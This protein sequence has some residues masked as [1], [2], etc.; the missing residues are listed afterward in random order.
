MMKLVDD[1]RNWSKWWSIRLSLIGGF[2]LAL[3]EAYP[4]A[5]GHVFSALPAEISGAISQDILKGVGI[6]CILASP[7]A[8]VIRQQRLGDKN[9]GKQ[10]DD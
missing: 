2:L 9:E 5:V 4:H 1:A 6:V 8:R 10:Q 3:L 7:I